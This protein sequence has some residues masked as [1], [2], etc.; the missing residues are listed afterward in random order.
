MNFHRLKQGHCFMERGQSY[1]SIVYDHMDKK[2][3]KET[4]TDCRLNPKQLLLDI[5]SKATEL[6]Y[7]HEFPDGLFRKR[8]RHYSEKV[9][10]ELL[11]VTL[12]IILPNNFTLN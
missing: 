2:V 6:E 1:R 5:E 7:F 12:H 10:R 3:R 11:V 9:I 8:V 4:W